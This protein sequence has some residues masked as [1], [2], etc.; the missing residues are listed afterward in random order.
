VPRLFNATA[1]PQTIKS[2]ARQQAPGM[3]THTN[4]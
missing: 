1:K 3:K 4:R 2:P